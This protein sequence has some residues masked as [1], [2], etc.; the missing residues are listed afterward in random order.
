MPDVRVIFAELPPGLLG[1]CDHD[2]R[3][4]W[5]TTG[6]SQRQRRAV[7]KHELLHLQR[8]RVFSHFVEAEELAVEVATAHAL[9]P[10]PALIDALRWTRDAH[11]L[12]DELWAPVDLVVVRMKHLHVSELCH[13]RRELS[14]LHESMTP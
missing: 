4:I 14:D 6:M 1:L 9:I 3:T 5:L 8:G 10:L 11:E 2:K 12:A 7:L 13:I